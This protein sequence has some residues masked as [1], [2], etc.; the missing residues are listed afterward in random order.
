MLDKDIAWGGS[1]GNESSCQLV[2]G[3]NRQWLK[4]FHTFDGFKFFEMRGR[5]PFEPRQS[6]N[7]IGHREDHEAG[8]YT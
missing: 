8:G 4:R 2:C 3:P 7:C 5:K 6:P 1:Q